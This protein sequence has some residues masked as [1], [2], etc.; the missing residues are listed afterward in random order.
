MLVCVFYY[1][2][3]VVFDVVGCVDYYCYCIYC[4]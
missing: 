1:V 3:G 4:C 2:L